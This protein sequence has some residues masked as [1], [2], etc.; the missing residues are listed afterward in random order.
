[1]CLTW[2]T[3]GT[4]SCDLNRS[5][6]MC[7][8]MGPTKLMFAWELELLADFF[9]YASCH[10]TIGRRRSS[11][12]SIRGIQASTRHSDTPTS[13]VETAPVFEGAT[14]LRQDGVAVQDAKRL[15]TSRCGGPE[16]LVH[17]AP[18]QRGL[19]RCGAERVDI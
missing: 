16:A 7:G 14:T 4:W 15:F 8:Q 19:C 17:D 9:L 12:G 2:S 3:F 18:R 6:S 11:I 13:S 5:K 10:Q 1:M